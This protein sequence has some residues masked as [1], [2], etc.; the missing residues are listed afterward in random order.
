MAAKHGRARVT[1]KATTVRLEPDVRKGLNVLA[2]HL[3]Q[4]QN[5]LIN[6]AVRGLI[7][8]RSAED[9]HESLRR[10]KAYR[11]ADPNFESAIAKFAEAE[12]TLA[13]EDPAEGELE[14]SKIGP[15]QNT[16]RGLLGG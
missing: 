4:P 16:V 3:K 1:V 15:M 6:E 7:K 12:A 5:K 9:M 8:K 11:S 14:P 2:K 10:L 13:G